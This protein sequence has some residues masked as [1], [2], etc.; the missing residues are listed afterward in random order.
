[1]WASTVARPSVLPSLKIALLAGPLASWGGGNDFLR[2]CAGGLW[3]KQRASL[4][5]FSLLLA[6]ENPFENLRRCLSPWKRMARQL[7]R[8]ERP[9]FTK[10]SSL[11][12]EQSLDS[13]DSFGGELHTILYRNLVQVLE[14]QKYGVILPFTASPG[15]FPLP[16]VG[17]IPDLQHKHHPEFFRP[18]E[19]ALR[20]RQFTRLLRD[21]RA[22]VV[23]SV[24]TKLDIE[25]FYPGYDRRIFAL[26]F[27]PIL[28][29]K[30]LETPPEEVVARYR[31]PWRYFLI[32]NQ[33]WAHKCHLTAF[34]ALS[35][36]GREHADV[37][38]ACT[39]S[40]ADYRQP[41]HFPM[42]QR[43]IAELGLDRRI[44]ILGRIPKH[45]Q[46]QIMR[47]AVAVIQPTLF[48]GGPGGG[49][50]YDAVSTGTPA[51]LSDI[52]V[53]REVETD[54]RRIRFFRAGS[55]GDLAEQMRAALERRPQPLARE[56][57]CRQSEARAERLGSRLLEAIR[58]AVPDGQDLS[59]GLPAKLIHP[60]H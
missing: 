11:G 43:R 30:W 23:N 25:R 57:L 16:W 53:N 20:D 48:E 24:D 37:A 33:F 45:D 21:A 1:M 41:E 17:Y 52:P 42:L 59:A 13:I 8:L 29:P 7:V 3:Q 12:P 18:K 34:Q 31:L 46:I 54:G 22:I 55:A 19:C 40:T 2:L 51:I 50:V 39:G 10:H 6:E 9:R 38:M 32:S 15:R 47:R 44:R 58:Y 35:L 4:L 36:L 26:P 60:L 27:A 49:A 28:N 5:T 56:E 14:R